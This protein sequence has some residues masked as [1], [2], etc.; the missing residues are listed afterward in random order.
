MLRNP[1][2]GIRVV[3][4]RADGRAN[5]TGGARLVRAAPR[6]AAR[7]RE[8]LRCR[9]PE[10]V[11]GLV[12]GPPLV[13]LHYRL[14][15][16]NAQSRPQHC[17]PDQVWALLPPV[18]EPSRITSLSFQRSAGTP[19]PPYVGM[20]KPE[21]ATLR[22]SSPNQ[23]SLDYAGAISAP[24][25]EDT[26][27]D[28]T[29]EPIGRFFLRCSHGSLPRRHRNNKSLRAN[30]GLAN[31]ANQRARTHSGP[32]LRSLDICGGAGHG[33]TY[34]PIALQVQQVPGT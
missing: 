34:A 11:G 1:T 23:S 26:P 4:S 20:L 19:H 10:S 5:F 3:P 17:R 31:N 27:P 6:I 29:S 16:T 9:N 30:R 24:P 21:R 22:S 8:P 13:W 7:N 14:R 2:E 32:R 33:L 15:R 12:F 28:G 18:L 25:N